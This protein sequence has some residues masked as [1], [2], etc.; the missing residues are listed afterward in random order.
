ML[1][2]TR[3]NNIHIL[4]PRTVNEI[5]I[6]MKW[7]KYTYIHNTHLPNGNVIIGISRH[8]FSTAHCSH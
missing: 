5:Q 1:A 7:S 6:D 4:I 3:K 8:L 2:S